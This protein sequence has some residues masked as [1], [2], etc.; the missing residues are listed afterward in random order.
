MEESLKRVKEG[1]LGRFKQQRRALEAERERQ[2]KLATR[3]M[4]SQ[5]SN[6]GYV[7]E[8]TRSRAQNDLGEHSRLQKERM[9][10]HLEWEL[11]CAERD[12][13]AVDAAFVPTPDPVPVYD[14]RVPPDHR[15]SHQVH[16]QPNLGMQHQRSQ[17]R[18]WNEQPHHMQAGQPYYDPYAQLHQQPAPQPRKRRKQKQPTVTR[19]PYIVYQLRD[20]DVMEDLR[21]FTPPT[22]APHHVAPGYYPMQAMPRQNVYA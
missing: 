4:E 19:T 12:K 14:N 9:I 5:V 18:A 16:G 17:K 1:R 22:Y 2:L 20:G 8:F 6:A 7:L 11:A 15:L 3:T 21:A 10:A 13:K